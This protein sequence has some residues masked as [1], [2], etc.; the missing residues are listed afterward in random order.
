MR[1]MYLHVVLADL[2]AREGIPFDLGH[3]LYMHAI[4]GGKAKHDRIEAQK[5][6]VLLRGGMLP[7][8][9]VYP[10]ERRATRALLRRRIHL[11][12]TRAEL[13]THVQHTNS[14]YNLP[15]IGQKMA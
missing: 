12:R 13:L 3:A 4:H 11:M 7:Q 9:S 6:A 10:S 8:A 5:I 15:E 14:P 2:G 1:G